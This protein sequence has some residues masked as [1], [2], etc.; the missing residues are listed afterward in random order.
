MHELS[1]LAE[2]CTQVVFEQAVKNI[3][4]YDDADTLAPGD[5]FSII[6]FGKL[7]GDELNYSSD[8]DLIGIFVGIRWVA[9][10]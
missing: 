10:G 4:R 9:I 7:G 3:L 6:A 2:A 5:Y 8:I 1:I